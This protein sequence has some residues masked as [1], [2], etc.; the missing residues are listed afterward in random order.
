MKRGAAMVKVVPAA[1]RNRAASGPVPAATALGPAVL[2]KAL[3]F[4]RERP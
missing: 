1:A 2:T 3:L 4:S